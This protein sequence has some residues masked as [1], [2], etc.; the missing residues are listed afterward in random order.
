MSKLYLRDIGS[1]PERDLEITLFKDGEL[2]F[3]ADNGKYVHINITSE[4]VKEL[5]NFLMEELCPIV[6]FGAGKVGVMRTSERGEDFD[7][8]IAFAYQREHTVGEVVPGRIGKSTD[9]VGCF[10]RFHFSN[11]DSV[12]VLIDDLMI[13]LDR[14]KRVE[15]LK[16]SES[17]K[18]CPEGHGTLFDDGG[19]LFCPVCKYTVSTNDS[20]YN[21]T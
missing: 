12:Q 2:Q 17:L 14:I 8:G 19:L 16:M 15:Q 5:V 11:S 7:S 4:G 10:L 13:V 6:E 18:D 1:H 3:E 21:K 20:L 9:E